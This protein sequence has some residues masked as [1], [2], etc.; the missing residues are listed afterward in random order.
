MGDIKAGVL[1]LCLDVDPL[2][3]VGRRL[4]ECVQ[5]PETRDLESPAVE[6]V[7]HSCVWKNILFEKRLKIFQCPQK[8]LSFHKTFV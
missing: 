4:H 8:Y 1:Q 7:Q 2:P 6:T 5:E 3:E